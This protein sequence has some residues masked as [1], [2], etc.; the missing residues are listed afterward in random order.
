LFRDNTGNINL[1]DVRRLGTMYTAIREQE[2]QEY[3][4]ARRRVNGEKFMVMSMWYFGSSP[5]VH[6]ASHGRR[7]NQRIMQQ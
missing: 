2:K 1:I 7:K 6:V 5:L 4:P 3:V